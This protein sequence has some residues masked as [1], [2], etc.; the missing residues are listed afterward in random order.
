MTEFTKHENDDQTPSDTVSD[1]SSPNNDKR[2][3]DEFDGL[4]AIYNESGVKLPLSD[5][6]ARIEKLYRHIGE[7]QSQVSV[8]L[9]TDDEIHELNKTWRDV[10][11][12]TDVL[13]FPMRE[14]EDP[15]FAKKLPLG[16]IVISIDTALRYV[17]SCHHKTRLDSAGPA[18]LTDSW[19]IL[20][21]MTF[22]VIHSTL[23]LLG[24]DHATP[25]E[26]T[27]MRALERQ[28]MTYILDSE[29]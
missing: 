14:G 21:E 15:E 23:H 24:Y 20:D 7:E 19:S 12:P 2:E 5:L 29:K 10:D 9:T 16:D 27:Q 26:E 11:A 17:D 1:T 4:H 8:V 3:E 28:W 22:L 18:P 6:H 25:E 13:S